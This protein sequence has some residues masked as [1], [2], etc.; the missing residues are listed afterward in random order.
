MRDGGS[1]SG[2]AGLIE[3][4]VAASV[5]GGAIRDRTKEMLSIADLAVGRLFRVYL[6]SARRA[7]R[8]E[9]PI[10]LAP[11]ANLSRVRGVSGEI[12]IGGDWRALVPEHRQ[13]AA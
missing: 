6:E 3:E 5:S 9:A 12:A 13:P 10:G 7:A 2:I 4:D 11:G 8:G 1:F